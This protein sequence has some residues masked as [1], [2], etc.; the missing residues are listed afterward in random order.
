[1]VEI[2]T[3]PSVFVDALISDIEASGLVPKGVRI[4][5]G[6]RSSMDCT[7]FPVRSGRPVKTRY[8]WCEDVKIFIN[9]WL[10]GKLD[11]VRRVSEGRN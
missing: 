2:M 11:D 3:V 10:R 7:L 4:V 5:G 1:M 8:P 9:G 6:D